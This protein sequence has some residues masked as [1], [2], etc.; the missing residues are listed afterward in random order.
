MGFSRQEYW[1]GLPFPSPQ[2]L[3]NPG[4]KPTSPA[5]QV[6]SLPLNRLEALNFSR[7][8]QT[9]LSLVIQELRL[10]AT[11]AGGPGSIPGQG[12]RSQKPQ[13]RV[14]TPQLK[15]PP[16]IIKTHHSK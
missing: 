14:H 11:N 5:L 8:Y 15:I 13:L 10:Q 9:G 3:P 12:V 2:D 16:A 1:S 7:K 6:D 4:I